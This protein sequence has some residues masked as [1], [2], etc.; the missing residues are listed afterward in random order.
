[1]G[2]VG[3]LASLRRQIGRGAAAAC[4]LVFLSYLVLNSTL[5]THVDGYGQHFWGGLSVLWG[6]RYLFAVQPFLA[7]G[8]LGFDW[9]GSFVRTLGLALLAV[10]CFFNVLGAM[11]GQ[12]LMSTFAFSP[13]LEDP[14]GYVTNLLLRLGPRVSLLDAYEVA[15]P[16]QIGVLLALLLLSG[17][18]LVRIVR[19]GATARG[20]EATGS[21]AAE[22][23]AFRE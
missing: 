7:W 19:A 4:L 23:R 6:P 2:L 8:L 21:G 5:G 20:S 22:A 1:M 15:H 16:A 17:W 14:L 3:H 10:S 13:E 12:V 18:L 11:Y 9:K